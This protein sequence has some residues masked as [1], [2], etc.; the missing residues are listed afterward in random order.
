MGFVAGFIS[1]LIFHQI[2]L[3]LLVAAGV[4]H[5]T[6][7]SMQSVAPFGVPAV[8]S[9][10]FW[11]GVWGVVLAWLSRDW[12]VDASYFLKALLFGALALTAVVWFIVAPIKGLPLGFGFKGP[13]IITALCVNGAWGLGTAL[14]LCFLPN[15]RAA[16]LH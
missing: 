16:K 3:M 10:A 4:T 14:L 1:V 7:Y 6:P 5:A 15:G 2:A 9:A 8:L 11:G 12:R 13:G